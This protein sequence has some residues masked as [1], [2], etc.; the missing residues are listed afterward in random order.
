MHQEDALGIKFLLW[1]FFALACA[2]QTPQMTAIELENSLD[3]NLRG[4][5]AACAPPLRGASTNPVDSKVPI[6]T[7]CSEQMLLPTR[8]PKAHEPLMSGASV[9]AGQLRHKVPREAQRAFA[10]AGKLEQSPAITGERPSNMKKQRCMIRNSRTLTINSALNTRSLAAA[11]MP[12]QSCVAPWISIPDPGAPTTIL[13]SFCSKRETPL[14]RK[15]VRDQAL[16]LS[17]SNAQVHLFLGLLLVPYLETMADG[18]QHLQF[19]ARTMPQ[20]KRI[21]EELQTK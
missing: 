13:H 3:R 18:I 11:A 21:L 9:S 14:E 6:T 4:D 17:K 7:E 8:N 2:A 15:R 10:R 16:E 20:A 1:S 5:G 19:A 12:R